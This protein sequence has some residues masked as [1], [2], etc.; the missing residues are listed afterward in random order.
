MKIRNLSDKTRMHSSVQSVAVAVGGGGV[1]PSMHWAGVC[2]Y[3]SMHW[4]GCVYP[5][6]HWSGGCLSGGVSA[7]GVCLPKGCVCPGVSGQGGV[8]PG[9]LPH[10]H[11]EQNHR[12]LWKHNLAA[13]MLRTVNKEVGAASKRHWPSTTSLSIEVET[14]VSNAYSEELIVGSLVFSE[15]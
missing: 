8:C 15:Y 13:A 11:C 14:E 2:V 7:Q 5:S 3:P 6:M 12:P 4:V 1:Y 9:G 10:P